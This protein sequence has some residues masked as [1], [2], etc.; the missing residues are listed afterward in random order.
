MAKI[1]WTV[2]SENNA[3][4]PKYLNFTIAPPFPSFNVVTD[5]TILA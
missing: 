4:P 2:N 1:A 3:K 5:K